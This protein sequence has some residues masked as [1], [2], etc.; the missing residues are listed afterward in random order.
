MNKTD[1]DS[2]TMSIVIPVY[3]RV[4]IVKHTLDSV[5]AQT[6]RPLH[7][8]L[9]DNASSDGTFDMLRDWKEKNE[10]SE[11]TVTVIKEN[12]AGAS[13]ARNTGLRMVKSEFT[14]FFDSDDTMH[15][16]L[17]EEYMVAFD[18]PLN[19]DIVTCRCL[20]HRRS[21]RKFMLK[22]AKSGDILKRHLFHAVL[23]TQGYAAKTSLFHRVGGWTESLPVWNDLEL[24]VRLLLQH[25]V[26]GRIDRVLVDTYQLDESITGV[27]FSSKAGLW[28]KS[29][30]AIDDAIKIVSAN[31]K[32]EALNRIVNYRRMLLAAIYAREGA[33]VEA[34]RLY[35]DVMS[36]AKCDIRQRILL[37]VI[38]HYSRLGGR[39]AAFAAGLIL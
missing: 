25:P 21:G 35:S 4:G 1:C 37:P 13:A 10:T 3:N 33:H 31:E 5:A 24:G 8:I 14:M 6:W 38:Y 9:V 29:L 7:L 36:R 15:P 32:T 16:T 26:L 34:K 17:V 18:S 2:K 30:D 11:F 28:E 39:G 19:P 20:L 27:C 23:R 12:K 22:Y